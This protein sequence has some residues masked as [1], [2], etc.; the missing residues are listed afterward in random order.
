MRTNHP[1]ARMAQKSKRDAWLAEFDYRSLS[2]LEQQGD[3]EGQQQ[4]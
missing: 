2:P 1:L 3:K 4:D